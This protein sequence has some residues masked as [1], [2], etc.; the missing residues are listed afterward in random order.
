ME[1]MEDLGA[2]ALEQFRQAVALLNQAQAL[3]KK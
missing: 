1:D 2:A 3:L